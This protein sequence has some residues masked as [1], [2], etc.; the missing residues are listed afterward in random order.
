MPNRDST[1]RSAARLLIVLVASVLAW[2]AAAQDA[3]DD[4][5]DF[6][7]T[8]L[9]L[10]ELM[11]IDLEVTT[12]SKRSERLMDTAA[13][14]YVLTNEE[15]RRS[16]VASIPEALR[17][18]PGLN[19]A[20]VNGSIYAI[21]SRGFNGQY[22][23]KLLVLI[24]GRVVYSPLFSGVF[25]EL[26]DVMLEDLDRIEVIRGP[27]AAIWGANAV[28]G[29]INIITKPASET[30][31]GLVAA[32]LGSEE[33]YNLAI[34]QGGELD[35]G[36]WRVWGKTFE[37]DSLEA[38]D[39]SDGQDGMRSTRGGFR[40]D[41]A[42]KEGDS[43]TVSGGM[44]DITTDHLQALA[45]FTTPPVAITP[46]DGRSNGGHLLAR[47][48]RDLGPDEDV[49]VQ[50]FY[51][52]Y[53]RRNALYD[54][55]RDTVDVE[56]EHRFRPSAD[57][58][59][60][61][62]GGVRSSRSVI[63]SEVAPGNAQSYYNLFQLFAQDAIRLDAE[64]TLT[65]GSKIEHNSYTGWEFQPD[66]RLSYSPN[67][68]ET[69]WAS[70]S[71]AVRVPSLSDNEGLVNLAV[72]PDEPF[73]T[74]ATLVQ[75]Q[76]SESVDSEELLAAQLGY[77][78]Q[79]DDTLSLDFAA[80]YQQYSDLVTFEPGTGSQ[81][82][83]TTFLFPFIYDNKQEGRAVGFEA[84]AD[85]RPADDWEFQAAYWFTKLD[86]ENDRDSSNLVGEFGEGVAPENRFNLTAHHDIDEDWT[87]DATLFYVDD[88]DAFGVPD[89]VSGNVRLGWRPDDVSE[90]SLG[91]NNLFHDGDEEFGF[92]LA[93]I[94]TAVETSVYLKYTRRF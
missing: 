22:A 90:W 45:S 8:E 91:V 68:D 20:R 86:L 36:H 40:M 26:Q 64:T 38:L 13:A 23:S 84:V 15:I 92:E 33:R 14:V 67:A 35:D 10:E 29:V 60:I 61:W 49:S 55:E 69:Y 21:S 53:D 79:V 16:G 4:E 41:V 63:G 11:D 85:W 88:L 5:V 28:N 31:G 24:D 93:A 74:A 37:R 44:F 48:T 34:R 71:R 32:T 50:A 59:V 65:L 7:P 80:Y 9:S 75:L 46:F 83:P 78:V 56:V 42:P 70:I 43:L 77:R 52:R 82:G 39:G 47:W 72:V 27:G 12:V 54:E 76:G 81:L 17:L 51:D 2:P 1:R 30:Q 18:V 62:G 73:P 19:V 89:Y 58:Q 94:P 66:A 87:V 25:W 57:H 6:D 3:A